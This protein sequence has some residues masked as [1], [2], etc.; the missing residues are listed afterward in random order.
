MTMI[1]DINE[2]L[3]KYGYFATN[4]D[5]NYYSDDYKDKRDNDLVILGKR[6]TK[7][8]NAPSVKMKRC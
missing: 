2:V 7:W 5:I 6:R 1:D 8:I 4:V 3:R